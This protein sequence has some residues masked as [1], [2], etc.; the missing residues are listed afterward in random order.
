MELNP[1]LRTKVNLKTRDLFIKD[2]C[3]V[4]NSKKN[5]HLHHTKYFGEI[6]KEALEA[7]NLPLKE[8]EEYSSLEL[9]TIT[10]LVLGEHLQ[11]E[12][13]TFCDTCHREHHKETGDWSELTCNLDYY[14]KRRII[15]E[16]KRHVYC[17]DVLEPFLRSSVGKRFYGSDKNLLIETINSRF[18]GKVQKSYR[19]LNEELRRINSKYVITPKRN[20]NT[21]FW[22]VECYKEK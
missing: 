14:E 19:K 15:N 9:K 11:I 3:E 12:Y 6:V 17:E 7:L 8:T 16:L 22:I 5:L 10:S 21:R 4:C 13:I 20:R 2:K 18:N 1:Y